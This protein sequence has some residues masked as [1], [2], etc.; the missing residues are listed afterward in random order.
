MACKEGEPAGR[1]FL[2]PGARTRTWHRKEPARPRQRA[3]GFASGVLAYF[4]RFVKKVHSGRLLKYR[5][6][7]EKAKKVETLKIQGFSSNIFQK[8]PAA[9]HRCGGDR[10]AVGQ[11]Q[12]GAEKVRHPVAGGRQ[13]GRPGRWCAGARDEA[14]M[15]LEAG[16]FPVHARNN[17]EN[18]PEF[19]GAALPVVTGRGGPPA[20]SVLSAGGRIG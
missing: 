4:G 6:A 7:I 11:C 16:Q 10:P 12:I 1:V 2:C 18:L 19:T 20:A 14:A 15:A 13:A 9:Q 5:W 17:R 3:A 8:M